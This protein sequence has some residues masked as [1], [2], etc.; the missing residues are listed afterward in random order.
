MWW[1]FSSGDDT[2]TAST[3]TTTAK[4]KEEEEGK[5]RRIIDPQLLVEP[6]RPIIEGV[7]F[8]AKTCPP[9]TN[10]LE[11]NNN[12]CELPYG[13][14]WT[15]TAPNPKL[16]V[17]Q[18]DDDE[19][20]GGEGRLSS[21][22][23][24]PP[25]LC[26]TCLAYIN[27]HATV[28]YET[29]LWVCPLCD[30]ENVA[31]PMDLNHRLK[32][33]LTHPMVEYQQR[34]HRP[35]HSTDTNENDTRT[36]ILVVD[37]N[38]TAND[39]RGIVDA[40]EQFVRICHKK[41]HFP[42]TTRIGLIIFDQV[43]SIYQLGLVGIA[44]ADVYTPLEVVNDDNDNEDENDAL[45]QRKKVMEERAYLKDVHTVQDLESMKRCL[46]ATF[47]I[48]L[49][50]TNNKDSNE[51]TT[52]NTTTA[53]SSNKNLSRMEVLKRRKEDRLRKERKEAENNNN[54]KKENQTKKKKNNLRQEEDAE[55]PW[56]KHRR[57]MREKRPKRCVGEAIQC[58]IDLTV[59]GHPNPSRTSQILLFT[60]GCPNLG[61]GSVVV[62]NNDN[63]NNNNNNNN[64]KETSSKS[65]NGGVVDTSK[66]EKAIEY[67]DT[68]ATFALETGVGIDVFCSGVN[69]LGLPA[70]QALVEP[71]GG[72][73]VSHTSLNTVQLKRNLNFILQN[74]YT[75]RRSPLMLVDS[76][77]E[78]NG[79][80][81][82][83][84]EDDDDDDDDDCRVLLD[85]RTDS[86][87]TPSSLNGPGE[88]IPEDEENSSLLLNEKAAFAEGLS[89]ANKAGLHNGDGDD[90]DD[91][92]ELPLKAALEVSRTRVALGRVD[93]LS[94]ISVLLELNDTFVPETDTQ[95]FF[96][97]ISRHVDRKGQKL[98]TRVYT[99]RFP[100]AS[101]VTSFVESCNS[102]AVAVVLA[103]AAVYRTLHGREE[104]DQ[105]RDKVTAGDT[106]TLEK[107]A[108][109]AQLDIDATI[110]RISGAFRLLALE[111]SGTAK[112]QDS[113]LD[114]AFPPNLTNAL[115]LLYCMRRGPLIS[116]GPMRSMDDRAAQRGLFLRFPLRECISMMA[117]TLW[118]TGSLEEVNLSQQWFSMEAMPA[119]TLALWED[120]IIGADHYDFLYVWSGK[121]CT[122]AEYDEVRLQY[123]QFLLQRSKHRFPM[124]QLEV[125]EDGDSM[126]RRFTS[127]LA[128]SHA[129]AHEHQI[130]NFPQLAS[131]S[132]E[133]L[134]TLRSRF[135]FYK[136]DADAS[137]RMW[138]WNV[139]SATNVSR[140]D[141]M[142]LCV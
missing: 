77:Q 46:A 97:F 58:A 137:F 13:V 16:V 56:V 73:V 71:S 22:S 115:K 23:S 32:P 61:G 68:T 51:D 133:A 117:P 31:S 89:L 30:C 119:E 84:N 132:D 9:N 139:S 72:Y 28:D 42:Q 88:L 10:N 40:M 64:V 86:F 80:D 87:M 93:P 82:D 107:L 24:L 52:T 138:F 75:S 131:L 60:N 45:L 105:L 44:S 8:T 96:Q 18:D 54:N 69:V 123:E 25:V 108:H 34:L 1:P 100:V 125:L 130:A 48:S 81:D 128:P 101:D 109:E 7:T 103:K 121:K 116:P 12:C 74:T 124:P 90:D 136:A 112:K 2:T 141:G 20:G 36:L 76:Q 122:S 142:S 104:T 120:S 70:Y 11:S 134:A 127:Q 3:T 118:S 39:G 35:S 126:S 29:G 135:R 99:Y 110:Q 27:L 50:S 15:P 14:I 5:R 111:H 102:G 57:E 83:D 67:F 47:G 43:V 59:V 33:A 106:E 53:K 91:D 49:D 66:L 26:L 6:A 129:D 37:T 92:D 140:D 4:E 62:D 21:S 114:S 113:A 55:S 95:C 98:I 17:I 41:S 79:K 78:E 85:I 19:G 94:T 63:G 65:H 38:L